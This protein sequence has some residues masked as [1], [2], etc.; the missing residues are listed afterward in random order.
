MEQNVLPTCITYDKSRKILGFNNTERGIQMKRH[1]LLLLVVL[2]AAASLLAAAAYNTATVTSAGE[3]KVAATDA[4][5]VALS[6]NPEWSWE[7]KT[8]LKDATATIVN[9]E[10]HF[11]FG[12]GALGAFR[13][14]Q[15]NSVYE[16]IPLFNLR[17][18]SK[19]K[20]QVTISATGDLAPYITFGSCNQSGATQ[21]PATATWGSEGV[22]YDLG[23]INPI[24]NQGDMWNIRNIAVKISIP[25]GTNLTT[26][27]GTIV[28]TAVAIP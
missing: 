5:L 27:A 14:L 26:F 8:G 12:K 24:N 7:N 11:E 28:V 9:G 15:P 17:N 2:I 10:L 1:G 3:L 23:T 13:G 18:L 21:I 25:S 4:S 20:I 19:E 6:P 16:W 22:S